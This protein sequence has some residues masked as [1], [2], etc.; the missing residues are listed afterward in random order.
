[1]LGLFDKTNI[2]MKKFH[3]LVVM[4]LDCN[5]A[6]TY[7][8][9]GGVK[10]RHYMS[11]EPADILI[12]YIERHHLSKGKDICLDFYGGEP[13]LSFEQIKSISKRLKASAKKKG[14]KCSF[15]LVTNGTLL[16]GKKA[17][18]KTGMS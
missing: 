2:I 3:G 12:N 4:T 17:A 9:E 8:Y 18:E 5:L 1:M 7:C 15:G 11:S 6:C 10:G 14:L 16:T 13:L